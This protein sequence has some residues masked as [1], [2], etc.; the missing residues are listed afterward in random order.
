M[1]EEFATDAAKDAFIRRRV[2]V[3]T[4][5]N[6]AAKVLTLGVWFFLTPF[7]L[8]QLGASDY[9]LWI[10]IGSIAAYG[11]LLDFGIAT[12]VTKYVAQ[13]HAEGR[14]EQARS[15]VATTLWLY[16][17]L[18]LLAVLLSAILAPIIPSLLN[19]P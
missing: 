8:R 5:S 15:L 14:I 2:I 3:N 6:Y 1:S 18:G 7:L 12:A 11:S 13:F 9:G 19:I 16:I 4:V 17:G 10:L